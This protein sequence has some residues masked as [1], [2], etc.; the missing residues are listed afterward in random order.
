MSG[1]RGTQLRLAY[2]FK[3]TPHNGFCH[4]S[5]VKSTVQSSC[6]PFPSTS[7]THTAV[8]SRVSLSKSA[9][10]SMP[11]SSSRDCFHYV[12]PRLQNQQW[13]STEH[14]S[15]ASGDEPRPSRTSQCPSTLQNKLHSSFAGLLPTASLTSCRSLPLGSCSREHPLCSFLTTYNLHVP[16]Q[17]MCNYILFRYWPPSF[18]FQ[19]LDIKNCA[20]NTW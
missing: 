1:Y 15:K 13:L 4:C 5:E 16:C 12:T 10:A 6:R 20:I 14:H 3:N 11:D 2:A 17:H 18:Y 7:G 19:C 8:M 9:G